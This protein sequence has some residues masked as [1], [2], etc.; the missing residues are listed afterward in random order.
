L[1]IFSFFSPK[2]IKKILFEEKK[3]EFDY[4]QI[5]EGPFESLYENHPVLFNVPLSQCIDRIGKGFSPE[6]NHPLF[7]AAEIL[8]H[9]GIA[10][11]SEYL[12]NWYNKFTHK[13]IND[14]FSFKQGHINFSNSLRL[15]LTPRESFILPWEGSSPV[16]HKTPLYGPVSYEECKYELNR[17]KSLIISIQKYGYHLARSNNPVRGYLLASGNQYRFVIKGGQHRAAILSLMGYCDISVTWQPWWPRKIDAAEIDFWPQVLNG[18]Y[19]KKTALYMFESFFT[20]ANKY[21]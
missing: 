10:H 9:Q 3:R 20:I 14:I 7:V 17:I 16:S 2:K 5:N 6:F 15:D 8:N 1:K 19:D 21:E 12:F 11:S 18:K 13:H 4:I